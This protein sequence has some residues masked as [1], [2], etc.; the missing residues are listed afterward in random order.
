MDHTAQTDYP[1]ADVLARRHSPR[2]FNPEVELTDEQ[3]GSLLEAARWSA[4]S[5]NS[6]PWRLYVARRGTELFDA[7]VAALASGNQAWAAHAPVLIVNVAKMVTDEGKPEKWAPY[8][9]G[10]AAAHLSTQA[11]HM[12]LIVHQMG[13]FDA[14]AMRAAVGVDD[15]HQPWAV[16]AVGEHGRADL[17][18]EKLQ[19]RENTPR[20]RKSL[21]EIAPSWRG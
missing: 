3:I 4:S 12:G 8:D 5:S 6:Q 14:E 19:E 7:V 2:A 1:L 11:T 20:V 10:Q 9:V 21:D 16:L 17:L 13:G 15:D 18:P